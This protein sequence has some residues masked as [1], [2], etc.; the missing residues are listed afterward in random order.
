MRWFSERE[1]HKQT[2]SSDVPQPPTARPPMR[3]D[4][5]DGGLFDPEGTAEWVRAT[6]PTP[7]EIADRPR[8]VRKTI[9]DSFEQAF[10]TILGE[11]YP[12]FKREADKH[13]YEAVEEVLN[14]YHEWK[15]QL[16]KRTPEAL[17]K[18][19]EAPDHTSEASETVEP[20]RWPRWPPEKAE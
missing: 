17:D 5:L 18:P 1:E 9:R 8:K 4:L 7:E 13:R 6:L 14:D 20:S 3:G 12:A 2:E 11:R 10:E 19:S 16:N 15:A